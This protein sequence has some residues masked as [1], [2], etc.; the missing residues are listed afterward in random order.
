MKCFF[1]SFHRQKWGRKKRRNSQT[2]LHLVHCSQKTM[3]GWW[4][5]LCASNLGYSH[6]WL[7]LP[8]VDCHFFYS[9]LMDESVAFGYFKEIP[10][11]KAK[12]KTKKL[13]KWSTFWKFHSPEV[14]KKK[15]KSSQ[16]STF[17]FQ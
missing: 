10:K 14:S 16:T 7:N 1:D 2:V 6:I 13:E 9:F 12:R 17:G 11:N 3:E 5:K 15:S 8:R 4:L